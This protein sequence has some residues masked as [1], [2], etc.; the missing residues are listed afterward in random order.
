MCACIY[1]GTIKIRLEILIYCNL[2]DT[3]YKHGLIYTNAVAKVRALIL[4][5]QRTAGL[6]GYL[7][8]CLSVCLSVRLLSV[9]LRH[10]VTLGAVVAEAGCRLSEVTG[11]CEG[12]QRMNERTRSTAT[13]SATYRSYTCI[14]SFV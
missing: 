7:S 5:T 1:I 14:Q 11:Y 3:R 10:L 8:V 9:C 4:S 2:S 6:A 13:L 12:V